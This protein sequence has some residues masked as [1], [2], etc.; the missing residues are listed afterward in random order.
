MRMFTLQDQVCL[1]AH[2]N[3][4]AENNGE[5]KVPASDL[6]FSVVMPNAIMDTFENK[7]RD[8]FYRKPKGDE[9]AGD[10]ADQAEAP[11]DG[12]VKLRFPQLGDLPWARDYPGYALRIHFGIENADPIEVKGC[13][14][15]GIKFSPKDGGSVGISFT[16]TCKPTEEQAGRLYGLMGR[17]VTIDLVPPGDDDGQQELK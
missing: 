11:K 5:E 16:A 3:A 8:A 9:V 6:K 4:R 12:M 10:L 15:K 7:L 1:F 17:E 14:L 2:F 13:T